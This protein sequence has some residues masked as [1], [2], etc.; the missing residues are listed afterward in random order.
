MVSGVVQCVPWVSKF[1]S[2]VSRNSRGFRD[3][4][5]DFSGFPELHRCSRMFRGVSGGFSSVPGVSRGF[6]RVLI[7]FL[8]VSR[9]VPGI[10][11]S[12]R[13]FQGSQRV[14]GIFM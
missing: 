13:G 6:Q 7:V 12:F 11:R 10:S 4:Q 3:V 9:S 5:S 14:S 1:F 2:G 8:G